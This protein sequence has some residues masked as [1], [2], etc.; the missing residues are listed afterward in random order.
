MAIGRYIR[1]SR[2][3]GR[4]RGREEGGKLRIPGFDRASRLVLGASLVVAA[5]ATTLT[6]TSPPAAA[7]PGQTLVV[8]TTGTDSGNCVA[9]PCLTLGY[10]LSQAAARR[11][12]PPWSPVNT[13]SRR[14]LPAHEN[15]V[16]AALSPLRIESESG[17]AS[18]T[19]INAVGELNGIVVNADDVTIQALTIQGAGGEGILVTPPSLTIV[20]SSITGETVKD[21]V[22][23]NDDQCVST[24]EAPY[25]P[26]PSPDDGYGEAIHLESVT[27]STLTGNTVV[28]NVGGILLTDEV[29]PTDDNS[30]SDNDVSYNAVDS[31]ITLGRPEPRAVATSGPDT[32]R[33][34]PSQAG[35]F[36]NRIVDN[37]ASHNG[38]AGLLASAVVRGSRRI[39]KQLQGKHRIE[40]RPG[41]DI[42]PEPYDSPGRERQRRREQ[43]P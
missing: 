41:G 36:G 27:D 20:P 43:H 12:H 38:G 30:I 17:L 33:P 1:H 14:T 28:H 34:R 31:G 32:G 5:G 22:V 35:V 3:Q 37:D 29:G 11:H 13:S 42:D 21:D 2:E 16:G 15:V 7:S 40:R 24:P 6:A 26:H 10:A 19:V 25:C 8:S 23:D 9:S 18:N 39:R 4:L